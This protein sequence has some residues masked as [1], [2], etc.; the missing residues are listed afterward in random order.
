MSDAEAEATASG[1]L[2]YRRS[3]ARVAQLRASSVPSDRREAFDAALDR[4]AVEVAREHRASSKIPGN[5]PNASGDDGVG[6]VSTAVSSG[7][8]A[9][10]EGIHPVHFN[11]EGRRYVDSVRQTPR[12]EE[13][14][15]PYITGNAGAFFDGVVRGVVALS[16]QEK[17]AAAGKSGSWAVFASSANFAEA[18]LRASAD[19]RVHLYL[20]LPKNIEVVRRVVEEFPSRIR[21]THVAT[22]GD[23]EEEEDRVGFASADLQDL[24]DYP[25]VLDA[26]ATFTRLLE[27]RLR[28]GGTAFLTVGAPRRRGDALWTA[29][30]SLLSEAFRGEVAVDV[31]A[32]VLTRDTPTL[33]IAVTGFVSAS[34][35][36]A[37]MTDL[38]DALLSSSSSSSPPLHS[39]RFFSSFVEGSGARAQEAATRRR[40]EEVTQTMTDAAY[41][42]E[43]TKVADVIGRRMAQ[44]TGTSLPTK[45]RLPAAETLRA[46]HA[47]SPL[48][49][50]GDEGGGEVQ[51]EILQLD[52]RGAHVDPSS[53]PGQEGEDSWKLSSRRLKYIEDARD[54]EPRCHW[55]QLKL[56]ASEWE[57]LT[58]AWL[59]TGRPRRMVVVY[60]GSADGMHIP[61][62]A[63]MFPEAVI[64][65]YDG[66][67]FHPSVYAHPRI[68]VRDGREGYVTDETMPAIRDAAHADLR[69]HEKDGVALLFVSDIRG[70]KPTNENVHADM[71]SQARWCGV[72]GASHSLLKFRLPYPSPEGMPGVTSARPADFV[73]VADPTVTSVSPSSPS[74]K[75]LYLRGDVVPQLFAPVHTTETRL[76][77]RAPLG[78]HAYDALAYEEQLN[79]FNLGVRRTSHPLNPPLD[80]WLP[81]HDRAYESARLYHI[82]ENYVRSRFPDPVASS[83]V[84]VPSRSHYPLDPRVARLVFVVERHL[85]KHSHRTLAACVT[86]TLDDYHEELRKKALCK[87]SPEVCRQMGKRLGM[88]KKAVAVRD[89]RNMDAGVRRMFLHAVRDGVM[90]RKEAEEWKRTLTDGKK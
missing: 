18:V 15:A 55:G 70:G 13:G 7:I 56:L 44:L 73:N 41:Y 83:P 79:A 33:R 17:E 86:R 71:M 36:A 28:P 63:N 20:T 31:D 29:L 22:L 40:R 65:A 75:Y 78:L 48:R 53:A 21:L 16:S 24:R 68:R 8:H 23:D 84:L 85:A 34:V 25:L 46:V 1:F 14:A 54:L 37:R 42:E 66:R 30:T 77:V 3:V 89:E 64:H 61:V 60:A 45:T 81:G 58:D 4:V 88:W 2:A 6:A 5:L 9:F 10:R 51:N 67:R 69:G 47:G 12:R 74:F 26:L 82:A 80:L 19:T 32:H 76:V 72:L 38:Q 27:R 49:L 90:S 52:W 57:F 62:L 43:A 87:R 59:E 39:P 50:S 35:F 11:S